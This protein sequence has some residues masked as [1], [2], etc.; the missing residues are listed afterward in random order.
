[1]GFKNIHSLNS[2]E[3]AIEVKK[4]TYVKKNVE[5]SCN[6]HWGTFDCSIVSWLHVLYGRDRLGS[7]LY[8]L[9]NV[10]TTFENSQVV[11]E[12]WG[13]Y[14]MRTSDIYHFMNPDGMYGGEVIKQGGSA[15]Y[16]VGMIYE[17]R[18]W[19]YATPG[20]RAGQTITDPTMIPHANPNATEPENCAYHYPWTPYISAVIQ[21]SSCTADRFIVCQKDRRI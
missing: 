21:A 13:G 2:V 15:G 12:G 6:H 1:M 4:V 18:N 19:I 5:F 8:C 9:A 7:S 20:M 3:P 17:A 16:W 10:N 11:C 14:V